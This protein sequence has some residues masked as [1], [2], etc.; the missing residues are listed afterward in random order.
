MKKD[1]PLKLLESIQSKI[2]TD[3]RFNIRK[4]FSLFNE[5]ACA[6][7]V[8]RE[9]QEAQKKLDEMVGSVENCLNYLKA[10]KLKSPIE[11][12]LKLAVEKAKG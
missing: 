5:I 12:T 6:V 2:V 1:N 8:V 3:K 11:S 7:K 10:R 4:D 9:E